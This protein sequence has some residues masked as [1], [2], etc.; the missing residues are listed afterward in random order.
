MARRPAGRQAGC[1]PADSTRLYT[2]GTVPIAVL[3]FDFDPLLHLGS[4]LVVRWQTIALA[5]VIL[6]CLGVA[7]IVA[8]RASL[9][10]DDLLYL[11][12]GAVP[13][14]V[15]GGRLGDLIVRTDAY[16]GGP[17]SLVDASVGTLELGLAVVG[18]IATAACVGWLLDAPVRRWAHLLAVPV[19]LAV[20]AGKLT[21]VVGGSGQGLPLESAW[22]TAYLGPGPWGSLAPDLPSHPAQA[23]EGLATLA[24]ALALLAAQAAGS[25]RAPD[26]RLL[27]VAVAGWAAVRT[28]VSVVWRDPA[29]VGPIPA[30]GV[31]AAAIAVV[32]LVALAGPSL[33][34]SRR[35]SAGAPT[36]AEAQPSS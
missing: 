30:G 12:I 29:A 5:A 9:R 13:G 10:G 22:A 23:Y 33:W 11:A 27:L 19:L 18:G 8:R 15:V 3:A 17:A 4:S 1:R 32:A 7:G 36:P 28:V 31:V 35:A 26:G 6:L 16:G 24:V 14:A 21:M 20:G 25:L 34:R 2:A